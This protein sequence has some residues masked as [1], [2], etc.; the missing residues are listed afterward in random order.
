MPN[1]DAGDK[2]EIHVTDEE[3][4]DARAFI[5]M[6][7]ASKGV[8]KTVVREHFRMM[9]IVSKDESDWWREAMKKYRLDM[10]YVYLYDN[11]QGIILKKE[12]RIGNETLAYREEDDA[13]EV[14]A[15][16]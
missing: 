11:I 7:V 8:L 16:V 15:P 14:D 10:N 3:R 9:G 4:E 1:D 5:S 2:V 6:R 13:P 12:L